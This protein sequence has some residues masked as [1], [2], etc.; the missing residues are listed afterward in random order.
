MNCFQRF[1]RFQLAPLQH[2]IAFLPLRLPYR[3]LGTKKQHAE[4]AVAAA[5]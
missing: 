5:A 3:K 4:A 1:L 2:A